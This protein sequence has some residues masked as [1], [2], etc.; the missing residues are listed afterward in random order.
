M[1]T[2]WDLLIANFEDPKTAAL[3]RENIE[4]ISSG[5]SPYHAGAL[6]LGLKKAFELKKKKTQAPAPPA[7][8]EVV[9]LRCSDSNC[10]WHRTQMWRLVDI[11]TDLFCCLCPVHHRGNSYYQCTNC[12]SNRTG[13]CASC[14][15][16]G[17][18]FAQ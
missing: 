9:W 5:S 18:M 6:K 10:E 8:P 2:Q 11:G 7:P 1:E 13:N 4:D 14:Q 15:G 17:A 16:C 12:G 3:M